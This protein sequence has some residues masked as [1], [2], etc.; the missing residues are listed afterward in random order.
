MFQAL[1]LHQSEQIEELWV[2]EWVYIKKME[3]H[4]WWD[5]CNEK[6]KNK[7]VE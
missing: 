1:A 4:Y 2:F 6:N 3:L 5:N 7:L